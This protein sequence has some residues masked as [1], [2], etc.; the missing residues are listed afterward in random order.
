MTQAEAARTQPFGVLLVDKPSGPTS[1]DVVAFVRWALQVRAVGHCG[2]LDPAATGMLV[3]CV[4]EATKLVEA[5]SGVDK[6]YRARI[7]LGRSTTTADAEGETS[8]E[9]PV[10]AGVEARAKPVLEAM[11]GELSLPPPA[12]SAVRVAGQR[13]HD[14]ARAGEVVE[15]AERA[16]VI[17]SAE[18]I[19]VERE[20]ER[21][22][23]EATLDVGKGTYV[24]SIAE[25]LGRR[26]DLPAH[27]QTLRRLRCGGLDLQREEVV[28]GLIAEPLGAGRKGPRWQISLAKPVEAEGAEGAPIAETSN[29]ARRAAAR[30]FLRERLLMPWTCLPFE[31]RELGPSDATDPL[32]AR[33][34]QGQ[35]LRFDAALQA[36]FGLD[37][38]EGP[39]ALALPDSGELLIASRSCGRFA[40]ERWIRFAPVR[41]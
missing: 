4:G 16:M 23:V 33:L 17:R 9:L 25:E 32:L 40:P 13:A 29:E 8:S 39:C 15:L 12:Y 37:D 30:A 21:V 11:I 20:G 10:P 27:L 36:A 24:R 31:S 14:L 18:A 22:W 34:R 26:L 5:L 38:V 41:G 7:E 28:S 2:T 6:C 35:R 3:V 19:V 1:F